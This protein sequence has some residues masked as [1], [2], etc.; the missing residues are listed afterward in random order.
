MELS[1]GV[2][3][4]HKGKLGKPS[5]RVQ[6]GCKERRWLSEHGRKRRE[7]KECAITYFGCGRVRLLYMKRTSAARLEGGKEWFCF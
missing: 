7:E 3:T 1:H 5:K 6:K 4:K 2:T